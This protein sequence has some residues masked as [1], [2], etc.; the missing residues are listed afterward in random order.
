MGVPRDQ[1]P[2][3]VGRDVSEVPTGPAWVLLGPGDCG[4]F[5]PKGGEAGVWNTEIHRNKLDLR[6]NGNTSPHRLT[7][8]TR[9]EGSQRPQTKP[10]LQT[11][12]VVSDGRHTPPASP[13]LTTVQGPARL[14]MDLET[15][16]ITE[17]WQ[18]SSVADV[19]NYFNFGGLSS[20]PA[21]KLSFRHYPIMG[22]NG[23]TGERSE[24]QFEN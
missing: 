9:A 18:K 12:I 22:V 23:S 16:N 7:L 1:G 6:T 17:V 24:P 13:G 15:S 3:R 8:K 2:L 21:R 10:S 20:R 19:Y 14:T 5:L 4:S 11:P